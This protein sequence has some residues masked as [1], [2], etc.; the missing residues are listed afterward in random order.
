MKELTTQKLK[1]DEESPET[2]LAGRKALRLTAGQVLPGSGQSALRA[3]QGALGKESG[4][5]WFT[6]QKLG[7][8]SSAWSS[9]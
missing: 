2:P 8:D 4:R 7:V 3:A 9:L 6:R 1:K 5:K